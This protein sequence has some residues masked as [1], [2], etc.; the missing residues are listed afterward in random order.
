MPVSTESVI[1]LENQRDTLGG[2]CQALADR[3]CEPDRFL[4][5][6]L[7]KRRSGSH[8][9]RQSQGHPVSPGEPAAEAPADR[10]SRSGWGTARANWRGSQTSPAS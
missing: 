7:G 3:G 1:R 2:V 5:G 8:P 10:L 4:S 6:T 9:N